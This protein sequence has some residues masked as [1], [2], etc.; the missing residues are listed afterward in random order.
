[1]AYSVYLRCLACK[2]D[3]WCAAPSICACGS[4]R[5]YAPGPWPERSSSAPAERSS[6]ASSATF[7]LDLDGAEV[8][9]DAAPSSSALKLFEPPAEQLDGQSFLAD[10]ALGISPERKA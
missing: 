4:H 10:T 6:S 2:R 1:M 9:I 7:Q 8:R 3:E 5:E